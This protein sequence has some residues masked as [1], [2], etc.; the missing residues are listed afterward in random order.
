MSISSL[1]I[2][3]FY[4]IKNIY[5]QLSIGIMLIVCPAM[6]QTLSYYYRSDTYMLAMLFACISAYCLDTKGLAKKICGIIFL[7]LTLSMYQ[8]YI[9]VTCIL[10]LSKLILD[11]L[12]ESTVKNTIFKTLYFIIAGIIGL[13]LYYIIAL[14]CLK[15]FDLTFSAYSGAN[16]GALVGLSVWKSSISTIYNNFIQFIFGDNPY[17]LKNKYWHRA[18]FNGI[19]LL[20]TLVQT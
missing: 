15:I 14:I 4:N 13:L 10:L 1:I 20:I 9:G 6:S 12:R 8:S 18:L 7:I 2:I 11:L 5:A 3:K 17:L 19:F 16:K